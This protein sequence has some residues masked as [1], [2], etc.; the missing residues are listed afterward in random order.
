MKN[1]PRPHLHINNIVSNCLMTINHIALM[2]LCDQYRYF[3]CNPTVN[4]T[5]VLDV[6]R[7]HIGDII[8]YQHGLHFCQEADQPGEVLDQQL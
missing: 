5:I 2:L 7:P 8:A 4:G 1:H 3:S 6:V